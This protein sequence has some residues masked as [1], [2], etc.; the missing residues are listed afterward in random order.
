MFNQALL[1]VSGNVVSEPYIET[2]GNNRVP[3]LTLRIAWS[4]RKLDTATG[5]W[6]DANTSYAKVICWR[7]L[8][9]NLSMCLHKGDSIFLRGKLEVRNFVGRDGQPKTAVEVEAITLGPDLTRGVARFQRFK[10]D[11]PAELGDGANGEDYDGA[12]VDGDDDAS[13]LAAM[14]DGDPGADGAVG[15]GEFDDS[16]IDALERDTETAAAAF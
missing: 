14:A 11:K 7:K 1:I 13:A 15:E 12:G 2:V 16:A 9:E 10:P 6:S 4:T 8:A 5:E 3:K